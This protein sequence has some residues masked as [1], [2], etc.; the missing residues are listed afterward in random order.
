MLLDEPHGF[1]A[2]GGFQD[3]GVAVEYGESAAHGFPDQLV[4]IDNQEFHRHGLIHL[5]G[6]SKSYRIGGR[7]ATGSGRAGPPA[8]CRAG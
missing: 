8:D 3:G 2:V 4:I 5:Q 7:G 1:A 6:D